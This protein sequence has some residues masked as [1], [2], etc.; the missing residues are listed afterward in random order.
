M[1]V[2]DR[3]L[4]RPRYVRRKSVLR[5]F[6]EYPTI[7]FLVSATLSLIPAIALDKST[8][9]TETG[10]LL[11]KNMLTFSVL[12]WMCVTEELFFRG[13]LLKKLRKNILS[14]IVAGTM[15][16]SYY[17]VLTGVPLPTFPIFSL[18]GTMYGFGTEKYSLV[19]LMLFKMALFSTVLLA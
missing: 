13:I 7:S 16:G 15:Y 11:P 2:L 4:Q 12:A 17:V 8:P 18:M 1:G 3:A 19:E 9:V 14:Y 5:Y 6:A 10:T